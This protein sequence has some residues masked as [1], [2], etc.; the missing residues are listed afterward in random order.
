MTISILLHSNL[1]KVIKSFVRGSNSID[2]MVQEGVKPGDI[3]KIER[4]DGDK[5]HLYYRVVA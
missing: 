3:L 4:K 5:T 1:R 2:P